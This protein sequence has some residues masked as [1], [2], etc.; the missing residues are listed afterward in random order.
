MSAPCGATSQDEWR[1][2]RRLAARQHHPDVGGDTQVYL[3]VLAEVD[4]RYGRL[5]LGDGAGS[6]VVPALAATRR[7][8]RR[9]LVRRGRTLVRRGRTLARNFRAMLPRRWPGS[10]RYIQL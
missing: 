3:R 2:Q 7:A 10:R 5:A 4:A 6:L 8:G 1:R 9:S